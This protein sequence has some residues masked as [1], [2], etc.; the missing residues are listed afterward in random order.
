[1]EPKPIVL[2][3]ALAA[4]RAAERVRLESGALRPS[5]LSGRAYDPERGEFD[6]SAVVEAPLDV[7]VEN[8]VRKWRALGADERE[9]VRRSL[10]LEDNYTLIHFANRMAVRALNWSSPERCELGLIA[11]AMI[12]ESRIDGRDA[13]WA[14]GLLNHAAGAWRSRDGNL[15]ERVAAVA[16]PGMAKL[17]REGV[18]ST[19]EDW[20]YCERRTSNGVGLIKCGWAPYRPTVDLADIAERVG[21][22]VLSSRYTVDI[23]VAAE[24][25]SVWFDPSR[26]THAEQVLERARG[27][28]AIFGNLRRTVGGG[29]NQAVMVW[30]AEMPCPEDCVQLAA[31][32]GR[33]LAQEGT[34]VVGVSTA[35][36]FTLCV[37]G[38]FQQGVAPYESPETVADLADRIR[39]VL[40]ESAKAGAG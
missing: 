15:F 25:P 33:G 39:A 13:T 14:G 18:G 21:R 36:L 30:I 31:D 34:V 9:A 11:L 20:G 3:A 16:T 37:A 7:E 8:L 32:V 26:R 22:R 23:E 1:M 5:P 24:I 35:R 4:A 40:S 2:G 19:L 38:S 29:P 10:S 17:L 12:D 6:L 28:A 27:V